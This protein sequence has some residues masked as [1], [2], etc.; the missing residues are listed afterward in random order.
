MF[1]ELS[2]KRRMLLHSF[3]PSCLLAIVL[4]VYFPGR[5]FDDRQLQQQGQ[6]IIRHLADLS[7]EPMQQH[8][9]RLAAA[10]NARSELTKRVHRLLG[11]TRYCGVAQWRAACRLCETRLKQ[12]P[13]PITAEPQQLDAAI[14]R[15]LQVAGRCA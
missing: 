7:A 12:D 5:Q 11:A 10:A 13:S 14:T 1:K 9:L 3:L 15:L 6:L 4:A 2:I 8:A